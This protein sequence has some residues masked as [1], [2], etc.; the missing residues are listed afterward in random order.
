MDGANAVIMMCSTVAQCSDKFQVDQSIQCMGYGSL[1][2]TKPR[3][4]WS[5]DLPRANL[6]QG[7]RKSWLIEI[8]KHIFLCIQV[9]SLNEGEGFGSISNLFAIGNRFHVT[10][11]IVSPTI[12][13]KY[14]PLFSEYKILNAFLRGKKAMQAHVYNVAVKSYW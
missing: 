5:A 13:F 1:R 4:I 2:R 7:K 3:V 12:L 8:S 10:P 11:R 6:L 9:T 14:T